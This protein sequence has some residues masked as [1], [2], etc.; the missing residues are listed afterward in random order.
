[1]SIARDEQAWQCVAEKLRG[2]AESARAD[3]LNEHGASYRIHM[4]HARQ[5]G[6][7]LAIEVR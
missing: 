6:N 2:G 7:G 1:M 3:A 4:V 5:E